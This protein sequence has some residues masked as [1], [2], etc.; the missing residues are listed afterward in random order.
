MVLLIMDNNCNQIVVFQSEGSNVLEFEL[1]LAKREL[2]YFPVC[3]LW[4][5]DFQEF[6]DLSCY[7]IV[8]QEILNFSWSLSLDPQ[9]TCPRLAFRNSAWALATTWVQFL[10]SASN[11]RVVHIVSIHTILRNSY[12]KRFS[13]ENWSLPYGDVLNT[14]GIKSRLVPKHCCKLFGLVGFDNICERRIIFVSWNNH[15]NIAEFVWF[16]ILD[17]VDVSELCLRAFE[18]KGDL[19][20]LAVFEKG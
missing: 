3:C 6:V 15:A 16:V 12:S 11:K 9:S 20:V 14:V 19:S 10:R 17:K 8:S 5:A 18:F 7:F 2:N 4:R 1:I 13:F